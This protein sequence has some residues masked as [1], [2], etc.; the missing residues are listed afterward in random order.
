MTTDQYGID[1]KIDVNGRE[2]MVSI[3]CSGK[4]ITGIFW[5]QGKIRLRV[6][7]ADIKNKGAYR[8]S[9]FEGGD[10]LIPPA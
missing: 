10:D 5:R 7:M 9:R 2:I 3:G 6:E 8:R 4:A 1:V